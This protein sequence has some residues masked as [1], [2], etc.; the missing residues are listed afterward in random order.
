M[1][2]II[3]RYCWPI[4]HIEKFDN[5]MILPS[6]CQYCRD[7]EV[8]NI[9]LLPTL[10]WQSCKWNGDV[11]DNFQFRLFSLNFNS[12]FEP[13]SQFILTLNLNISM[14]LSLKRILILLIAE[15]FGLNMK[16]GFV[17]KF[18][19]YRTFGLTL[20][21]LKLKNCILTI[22]YGEDKV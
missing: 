20:K 3:L 22:Q 13:H 4:L 19:F 8:T 5:I 17:L 16:F 9:K 1:L 12:N 2:V 14:L 7:R 6:K 18:Y 10:L 15:N 11:L 21:G